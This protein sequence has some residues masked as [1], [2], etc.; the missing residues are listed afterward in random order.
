M[1]PPMFW[2]P[3]GANP[4]GIFESTNPPVICVKLESKTS[5][6]A[7]WKSVAKILPS[8]IASPLNTAPSPVLSTTT[9]DCVDLGGG[10]T[11]G[12]QPRIVPAS[13]A[14]MN[15][16]GPEWPFPSLTVKPEPPLKTIPVGP[17]STLT[18]S[19]FGWNC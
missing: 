6:F 14:N 18:T 16:D 13:V 3:N 10:G 12:F 15:T 19:G 9:N 4:E 8:P 1:F 17:P 5:T 7:L 11:F 2:I